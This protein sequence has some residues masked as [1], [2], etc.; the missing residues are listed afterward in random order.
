MLK[1]D[2]KADIYTYRVLFLFLCSLM[3]AL[4]GRY[5]YLQVIEYDRHFSK[6][7]INRV[8]AVT[9]YASRGLIFDR[10]GE[11]LVD[12]YPTYVLTVIPYKLDDKEKSFK[13]LSSILDTEFDEL[14][15]RYKKYYRGRMLPTIIAK[16]L[17]FQQISEIEERKLEFPAF[18]YRP[19]NERIY[20]SSFSHSHILGYLK[21]VD[22]ETVPSLDK[23]L[24]YR[25]GELIGWQGVEK[26]YERELRY[27]KGVSY[28]EVDT[29][30]REVFEL[31]DGKV[32][33]LPTSF[34]YQLIQVYNSSQRIC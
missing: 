18:E 3:V 28:L 30:G 7:Q 27:S 22:R 6:S 1:I 2:N 14:N 11:L 31:E 29:Y 34:I 13:E 20:P 12:N 32:V 33:A 15:R 21:E 9:T 23:S 8:K 10:N 19:F 4:I 24:L 26:Q 25:A 5:Y 16:N 17:S